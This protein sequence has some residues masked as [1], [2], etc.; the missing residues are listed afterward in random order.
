VHAK[1]VAVNEY[2]ETVQST[3]GNGA[4]YS[5]VPDSPINLAEDIS[6]RAIATNGLVWTDGTNNGGVPII[7]YRI[8]MREQGGDYSVLAIGVTAQSYTASGLVLGTTYD[9]TVEARNSVGYSPVSS[10]LTFLHALVPA[11]PSAPTVTNDD[12]SVII[13][14]TAPSDNG[15]EITG[16]KILIRESDDVTFTQES[17]SCESTN[18]TLLSTTQCEVPIATLTAAP[19]SLTIGEGIFVKV[20]ATNS[21]GD[22]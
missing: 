3:E 7:D 17:V 16:Y 2:G 22:S 11:T 12:T 1:V 10:T 14:W 21:K 6:Q 8:N 13:D 18:P 5:R 4:Y 15:A 19:Y 9:F 20:V